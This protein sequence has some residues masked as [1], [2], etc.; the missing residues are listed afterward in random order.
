SVTEVGPIADWN[1]SA[2]GSTSVIVVDQSGSGAV[3]NGLA[4]ARDTNNAPHI[5]AADFHN[6]KVDMF[7]GQFQFVRSFTDPDLPDLFAPFN[8]RN[9]RGRVF[10]SFAK[11][12]LP[13]ARDDQAGPGNGFVDIFDT[14]G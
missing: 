5:Y 1:H 14:D 4:I 9:F 8:V 3:Y 6:G 12:R 7:D 13:D 2:T 10:V 11:Q